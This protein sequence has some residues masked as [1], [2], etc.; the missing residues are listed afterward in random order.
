[1]IHLST[2]AFM[3]FSPMVNTMTVWT[4]RGGQ[5]LTASGENYVVEGILQPGS[6]YDVREFDYRTRIRESDGTVHCI[7]E[8]I[9]KYYGVDSSASTIAIED[10]DRDED[11]SSEEAEA[12]EAGEDV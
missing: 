2:G 5:L 11:M 6:M 1:M 8:E 9:M 3:V 4:L 12:T 10:E 7:H